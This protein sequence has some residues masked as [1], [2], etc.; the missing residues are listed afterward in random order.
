MSRVQWRRFAFFEKDSVDENITDALGS[1][2]TCASAEGG[3]LL[4]GDNDG[5]ITLADRNFKLL[6]K[7]KA[8]KGEVKGLAYVYDPAN[9]RKQYV[10]AVGDEFVH[11][12][13]E[14]ASAMSQA[15][16]TF[17][18]LKIFNANDMSR[19]L[20]VF[21]A[22]PGVTPVATVTAFSVLSDGCQIALG[23]STGTLLLFSGN[24]LKN[25]GEGSMTMV[26][27]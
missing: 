15:Q 11:H 4:F 5:N 12:S 18:M 23:F 8:F 21:H 27:K 13:G 24:F 26:S 14:S 6:W 17:Y 25:A 9:H 1:S 7:C 19:P 10:F 3:M 20:H 2:P 22:S 16:E